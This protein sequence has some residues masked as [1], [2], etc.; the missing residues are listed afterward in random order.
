MIFLLSKVPTSRNI[1]NYISYQ[2][3]LITVPWNSRTTRVFVHTAWSVSSDPSSNFRLLKLYVNILT[4]TVKPLIT[5]HSRSLQ[6]RPLF[7]DVRY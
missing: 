5:V 7:G 3:F 2:N 6:F 4:I 1:Q